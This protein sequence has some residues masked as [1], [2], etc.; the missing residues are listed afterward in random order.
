MTN[1]AAARFAKR[2]PSAIAAYV[3]LAVI[4]VLWAVTSD[5]LGVLS[6]TSSLAQKVPLVAVAI[7]EAIVIM[8]RGIDLSVGA[9][10]TFVN[11]IIAAGTASGGNVILYVFIGLLAAVV[12]GLVNGLLTAYLSLPPLIV[13][14]ATQTILFGV[15]LY[16]LPVPGG[17]VPYSFAKISMMTLGPFPLALII[18]FAIPLLAW[19]PLQR[20]RFG[21][22]LLAVGSDRDAAYVSG[23]PVRRTIVQSYV[24]A[25]VFAG[26]GGILIT[27]NAGSGDPTIGQPYTLNAIAAAVIGGV[28]LAGGRG[29]IIGTCAG[30]LVLS[31]INNLLFSLGVNTY[32]QYIVTGTVLVLAL[33]I[34]YVASRIRSLRRVQA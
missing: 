7:G 23:I 25:A 20:S 2:E 13:T 28:S 21:N 27:M 31:F 4:L 6:I 32:W 10:L 16:I 24:L 15:C 14:L 18:L 19:W 12:V 5:N 1:T 33:G 9:T 3:V 11:V 8:G 34:P 17:D 22:Y 30:A 26:I 29:S